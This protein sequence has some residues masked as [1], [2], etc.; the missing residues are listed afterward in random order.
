MERPFE[1]RLHGGTL[2]QSVDVV[3][4]VGLCLDQQGGDVVIASLE[5][6]P[7]HQ[8]LARLLQVV[9]MLPDDG[10]YFFVLHKIR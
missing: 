1:P 3:A 8:G 7:V 9:G 6:R 2:N 10:R 4:L 5:V